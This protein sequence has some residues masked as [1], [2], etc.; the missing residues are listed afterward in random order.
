MLKGQIQKKFFHV[1]RSKQ[2]EKWHVKE[3]NGGTIDAFYQK[4]D[5]VAKAMELAEA[6]KAPSRC[7]IVHKTNGSFDTVKE[8]ENTFIN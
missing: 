2:D 8:L 1:L 7:V 5:A 6:A 3:D 4:N